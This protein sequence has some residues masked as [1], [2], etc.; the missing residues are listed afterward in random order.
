MTNVGD[1]NFVRCDRIENEIPLSR[2]ND[3]AYVWF[4]CFS[5][6]KR[7]VRKAARAFDKTR[8]EARCNRRTILADISMNLCEVAVPCG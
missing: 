3:N 2:R 6:R 1:E 8:N 4:V 5:T 7:L